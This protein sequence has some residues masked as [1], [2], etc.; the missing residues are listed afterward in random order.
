[1]GIV[2]IRFS[3]I[4]VNKPL[5]F[6]VVVELAANLKFNHRLCFFW[7]LLDLHLRFQGSDLA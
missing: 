3:Y 2:F 5:S 6:M 7:P 1:M 4:E